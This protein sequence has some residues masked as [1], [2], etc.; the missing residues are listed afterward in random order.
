METRILDKINEFELIIQTNDIR[1]LS[2]LSVPM[3]DVI[4]DISTYEVLPK[5]INNKFIVVIDNDNLVGFAS[6]MCQ[7]GKLDGCEFLAIHSVAEPGDLRYKNEFVLDK[8][9]EILANLNIPLTFRRIRSDSLTIPAFDKVFRKKGIVVHRE[10]ADYPYIL[11]KSNDNDPMSLLSTRLKSD[12]RRAQRKA[13]SL[14]VVSYEIHTPKTEHEF[15]SLYENV[16][17]T[18]AAGWKGRIGTALACNSVLN[19][20]FRRYG[21]RAANRGIL[22][23][24]FMRI[25]SEVVAMQFAVVYDNRFWLLKIGYNEDYKICSPG[26]LLMLK[27]LCYAFENNFSSYEFLGASEAWTNRWT[28]LSR[29]TVRLLY[30]PYNFVG[31]LALSK[32]T[33]RRIKNRLLIIL[34]LLK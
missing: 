12:L 27:T 1:D 22:R 33:F 4:W 20:F 34:G 11:L 25:N 15:L 24:A 3:Q 26:N 28:K 21:I 31:I 17:N 7:P 29:S 8:L 13:D 16:M 30:F 6:I 9:L 23:L 10:Q 2:S 19:D 32:F 18:E 5:N 14:G